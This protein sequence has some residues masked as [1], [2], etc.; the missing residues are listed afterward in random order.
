MRS[1]RGR[2]PP[3]LLRLLVLPEC[4]EL[5]VAQQAVARLASSRTHRL[6]RSNLLE[7]WDTC[8]DFI[9]QLPGESL[10]KAIAQIYVEA[11]LERPVISNP[12]S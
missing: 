1:R 2:L 10:A 9:A 4:D 11:S 5:C 3:N 7:Y 6:Q 8:D 12:V